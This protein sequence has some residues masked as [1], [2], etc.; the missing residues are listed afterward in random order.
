MDGK[1]IIDNAKELHKITSKRFKDRSGDRCGMLIIIK[2]SG[3]NKQKDVLWE[4]L[5]DCG[6]VKNI[7]SSS[8]TGKKTISCGCLTK[9]HFNDITGNRYNKLLVKRYVGKNTYKNN[10]WECICDCGKVVISEYSDITR[11]R[12]KSCGCMKVINSIKKHTLPFGESSK[13]ALY[14][15]YKF[16][17]NERGLEFA[18]SKEEFIAITI[19]NCHYCGI[20]PRKTMS[21]SVKGNGH[22]TYN[23]IDRVDNREGYTSQNSVAACTTCNQAKHATTVE[24]F[25]EWILRAADHIRSR[26]QRVND[27]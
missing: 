21:G 6:T 22:H 16:R 2:V 8:L 23:G 24:Y 11:E 7:A 4:C 12:I 17:A 18:L 19:K 26:Q 13:N 20:E 1:N 10:L 3:K 15:Q 25:E 27:V 5:C 14:S 9:Q